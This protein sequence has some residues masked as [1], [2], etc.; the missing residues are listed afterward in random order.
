MS[1]LRRFVD[2]S[3]SLRCSKS[4]STGVIIGKKFV[5]DAGFGDCPMQITF[6]FL[7]S[8]GKSRIGKHIGTESSYFGVKVGDQILVRYIE[9]DP[10]ICAPADSLGMIMPISAPK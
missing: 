4:E 9:K 1:F 10:E 7:D 2:H 3:S 5:K 6:E 8:T